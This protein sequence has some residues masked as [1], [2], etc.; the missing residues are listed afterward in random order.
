MSELRHKFLMAQESE[1][2]PLTEKALPECLEMIRLA[3][4]FF[5]MTGFITKD[6]TFYMADCLSSKETLDKYGIGFIYDVEEYLKTLQTV[7][8]VKA[9][10]FVPSHA[11][12]TDDITALADYNI[13]K[14]GEISDRII[15]IC[16]APINFE[17][18]LQKLFFAYSL[19]MT[20]EQYALVGS[21][22]RSYLA[23]LKE[24]GRIEA[25]FK[26]NMLLW[27]AV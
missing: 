23:Y 14:V 16:A 7:K 26:D 6:G 11:E 20:F 18:I 24:M 3:G 1:V 2:L 21:T 10:I 4:H 12:A 27:K 9:K 17:G 13:L 15:D 22:V 25:E 5:D 8:T 19:K